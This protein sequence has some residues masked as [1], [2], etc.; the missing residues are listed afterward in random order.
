MTILEVPFTK[1]LFLTVV[2][3]LTAMV[4]DATP[5]AAQGVTTTILEY[6]AEGRVIGAT[7][8]ASLARAGIFQ[9][10]EIVRI[11]SLRGSHRQPGAQ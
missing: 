3:A 10:R 1:M 7:Q 11:E 8:I 2:A 5:A 6:D 4:L 9:A